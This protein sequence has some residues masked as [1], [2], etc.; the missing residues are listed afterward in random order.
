MLLL[1]DD[2]KHGLFVIAEP[3]GVLITNHFY[4]YLWKGICDNLFNL[5]FSY[6]LPQKSWHH[7]HKTASKSS[8]V[9]KLLMDAAIFAVLMYSLY[10]HP[11]NVKFKGKYQQYDP[12]FQTIFLLLMTMKIIMNILFIRDVIAKNQQILLS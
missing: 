5:Y 8:S 9:R 1:W 10:S 7:S 2:S 11:R 6:Q 12:C 3:G 4:C